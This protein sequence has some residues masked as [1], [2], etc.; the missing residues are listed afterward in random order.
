LALGNAA[1]S[2]KN[3]RIVGAV[4]GPIPGQRQQQRVVAVRGRP[5]A[6]G[7]DGRAL[8]LFGGDGDVAQVRLSI[9]AQSADCTADR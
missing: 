1:A 4:I 9:T 8:D 7:L 6:V 2:P 5:V 3:A